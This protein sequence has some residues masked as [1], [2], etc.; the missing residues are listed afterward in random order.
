MHTV[1]GQPNEIYRASA[2]SQWRLFKTMLKSATE[3]WLKLNV[4]HAGQFFLTL[5][6]VRDASTPCLREDGHALFHFCVKG[7]RTAAEVDDSCAY[8]SGWEHHLTHLQRHQWQKEYRTP[9]NVFCDHHERK[10]CR[11]SF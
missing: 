8:S 2:L 10:L 7:K 9:K 6:I 11:D 1:G 3:V 4:G 5:L